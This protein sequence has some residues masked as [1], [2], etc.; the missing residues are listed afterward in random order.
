MMR[1]V[2]P[3]AL[4]ALWPI[5]NAGLGRPITRRAPGNKKRRPGEGRRFLN[6]KRNGR[7]GALLAATQ[8]RRTGKAR[9]EQ[10]KRE[11]LGH[12][13]RSANDP[14]FLS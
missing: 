5:W 7:L 14:S 6:T 12:R 2:A 11:G 9:A 1:R 8:S 13:H 4:P 3:W 10:G